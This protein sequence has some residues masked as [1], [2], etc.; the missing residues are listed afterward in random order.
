M[1]VVTAEDAGG[2]AQWERGK[3][4]GK[5]VSPAVSTD[6]D[7]VIAYFCR[8]VR[9]QSREHREAM[10]VVHKSG[11]RSIEI[12][13]L[14]QE[15]DSMNRVLYLL[16]EKNHDKRPGLLQS[17]TSGEKWGIRDGEIA[18]SARRLGG[19]VGGSSL[20]VW[21]SIHTSLLSA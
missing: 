6:T 16:E 10:P 17:I 14:R 5:S 20:Q 12:G 8:Q 2:S 4:A 9:A 19:W 11:W 21:K 3:K 7:D 13:I 15:L 18:K 1:G